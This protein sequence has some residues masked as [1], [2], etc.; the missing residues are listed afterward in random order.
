MG[1]GSLW[2][3]VKKNR[4]YLTNDRNL[5]DA[6]VLGL[7]LRDNPWGG[8]VAGKYF[9][10]ALNANVLHHTFSQ[11]LK[12]SDVMAQFLAILAGLDYL[13]VESDDGV[14]ARVELVMKD[15]RQNFLQTMWR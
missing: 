9:Y 13:T 12:G 8:E 10:L 3:G 15:K 7:S 14:N 1:K 4:F 6:R 5:V 11:Q 2:L